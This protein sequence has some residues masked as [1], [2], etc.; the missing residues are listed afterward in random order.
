MKISFYKLALIGFSIF[1]LGGCARVQEL[2]STALMARGPAAEANSTG[3]VGLPTPGGEESISV[4]FEKIMILTSIVSRQTYLVPASTE[5]FTRA[6]HNG[7]HFHRS[8]DVFS[9][10]SAQAHLNSQVSA[11]QNSINT[12]VAFYLSPRDSDQLLNLRLLNADGSEHGAQENVPTADYYG[13]TLQFTRR[14]ETR[15][16]DTQG[17]MNAAGAPRSAQYSRA[18]VIVWK[19]TAETIDF[20]A[21]WRTLET[22]DYVLRAEYLDGHQRHSVIKIRDRLLFDGE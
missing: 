21:G 2:K 3:N 13:R 7:S 8:G 9:S 14:Q 4:P 5:Q 1:V 6:F 15:W 18:C 22:G 12:Y 10:L 16:C 20:W 19:N 11:R 17:E